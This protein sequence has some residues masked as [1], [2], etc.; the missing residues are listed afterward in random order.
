MR[1]VFSIAACLIFAVT[2]AEGQEQMVPPAGPGVFTAKEAAPGTFHLV[3]AGHQF[4]SRGE[5][6]KY[7][8]YRAARLTVEK[9]G[10]W[11]HFVEER[12]KGESMEPVPARDP[13]A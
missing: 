2:G 10:N 4:T 9:G 7:L 11:F 3:V 1:S 12:A 13:A 8:A 5:A 6:E